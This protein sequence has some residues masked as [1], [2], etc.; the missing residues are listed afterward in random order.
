[1]LNKKALIPFLFTIIILSSYSSMFVTRKTA[2][3]LLYPTVSITPTASTVAV[4][5]NI[6]V[7]IVISNAVDLFTYQ[8]FLSYSPGF[9]S[10][11]NIIEGDLL[12]RSGAYATV[13]R[14]VN[15]TPGLIQAADS[16]LKGGQLVSGGGEAFIV[17]FTANKAGGS[18][19]L[20]H[21]IILMNNFGTPFEPVF[22]E[23][24]TIS[25][26]ALE[27]T[28]SLIRPDASNDLGINKTFN[29]NLTLAGEV[30]R[31]Y[32]Y[33]LN[34]TY[35]KDI[36]EATEANLLPLMGTPN[37]NLTLIDNENGVVSL[38][39]ECTPPAQSTNTAGTLATITF[40]VIKLGET[41]IEINE[42]ST[43]VDEDGLQLFLLLGAASFNNQYANRN[44]GIVSFDL[45]SYEATAGNNVTAMTVVRNY[46]TTNETYELVVHAYSTQNNSIALVGG[47]STL[48]IEA[49]TTNSMNMTLQTTGLAGNYTVQ[50]F[51]F[52]LPEETN[53]QDN[54]YAATQEL[55]VQ[56]STEESS[57]FG[58][59]FYV[60]VAVIVI[61]IAI[62]AAYLL[63]RRKKLTNVAQKA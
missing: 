10:V 51:V 43:L 31:L 6:N 37:T 59:L 49:N 36:L 54:S 42:T 30:S 38:S 45:A 18:E 24:A 41:N 60:V 57:P 4:N 16:L 17:T 8:V 26:A 48:T 39:L 1:M 13:W 55:Q 14:A 12:K 62:A 21:D 20:L 33:D 2:A 25:T 44:I 11:T 23:N 40:K 28:P 52:Y 35:G 61:A 47:P 46:G 56:P 32:K 15:S 53:Y 3:Q 58:T 7:S 29:V 5:E 9:L 63:R 19:L 34:V 27:I 50:A 22:T